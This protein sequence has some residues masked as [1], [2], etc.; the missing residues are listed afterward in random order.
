MAAGIVS[1][2]GVHHGAGHLSMGMVIGAAMMGATMAARAVTGAMGGAGA[3]AG[4]AGSGGVVH[5]AL[6][7]TTTH[8]ERCWQIE[9]KAQRNRM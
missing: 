1:G 9:R 7:C 5:N 8:F 3:V 4:L 6:F 2:G